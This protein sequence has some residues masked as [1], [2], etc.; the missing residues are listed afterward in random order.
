MK[1][2]AAICISM[3]SAFFLVNTAFAVLF[4]GSPTPTLSPIFG[5]LVDFDDYATGSAV[6]AGDYAALGVASITET[7]GFA[8]N[9]YAGTQSQPN[10]IGTG[11]NHGWDGTILFEFASL[12]DMVGIGIADGAGADF[13][14]AF[15]INMNVLESYQ[16]PLGLNSYAG[17]NTGAFNIKYFSVSG[18][19]FA[20]DDL[21]FTAAS[22]VPEPSLMLL[23]G[24]GV[25]GL[26]VT[27]RKRTKK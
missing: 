25:L 16:A 10:Y 4:T 21:Q 26:V 18:D 8:L 3:L 2:L 9:Y 13:I 22:S 12:A 1:K 24:S 27:S 17:I 15:D 23:L 20:V 14:T 5:T 11:P 19:F 7:N 6:G